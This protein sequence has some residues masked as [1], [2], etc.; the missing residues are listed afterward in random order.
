MYSK[1]MLKVHFHSD[2]GYFA[3]CENM[4]PPLFSELSKN[5]EFQTTFSYRY[6]YKYEQGLRKKVERKFSEYP[7][8]YLD[9]GERSKYPAWLPA[10][11]GWL[12][13]R[14]WIVVGLP[15]LLVYQIFDLYLLLRKLRPDVLHVNNGGYPAA[16]SARAAIIAG[17]L[18][19]IPL[20]IMVVNNL[21]QDYKSIYRFMDYPLDRLVSIF[22]D[23]FVT[24][25]Q[26]AMLK[27]RSVLGLPERKTLVIPNG[28]IGPT[29]YSVY[30]TPEYKN[31]R[32]FTG[33]TFSIIAELVPRK[34]HIY[35]LEAVKMLRD[36]EVINRMDFKLLVVG[37]GPLYSELNKY[38][39]ENKLEELVF[40]EGYLDDIFEILERTDVVILPS[41]GYED[42]PYVVLEGMS[43]AKPIIGSFVAGIPEQIDH[44]VTGLLVSP[45]NVMELAR[46]IEVLHTQP[47]TRKIF[48]TKGR[49]KFLASFT[50][51][52]AVEKYCQLYRSAIGL[53]KEKR[54]KVKH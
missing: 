49:E 12:F 11:L 44:Q 20:K 7:R 17:K 43:M 39:L 40:F 29:S 35:L 30:S 38:T 22:T 13:L 15:I 37:E 33:V 24:G 53:R 2:C 36:S 31:Y 34:G 52:I 50:S 8:N 47:L 28:I 21:A 3:G 14:F 51:K 41:I 32:T 42:F 25:S 45:K 23:V 48:G 4:L 46:A 27:L 6:S 1:G 54:G 5:Q 19:G 26:S 10:F 9:L 18:C 16:T